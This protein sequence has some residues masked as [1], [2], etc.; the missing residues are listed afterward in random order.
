MAGAGCTCRE[1]D[2]GSRNCHAEYCAAS[3][4]SAAKSVSGGDCVTGSCAYNIVGDTNGGPRVCRCWPAKK[5]KR[6]GAEERNFHDA[7]WIEAA[8]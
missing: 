2:N 7:R 5:C 1:D 6:N 8:P 4:D 3:A